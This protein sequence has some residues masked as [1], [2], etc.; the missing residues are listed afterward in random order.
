MTLNARTCDPIRIITLRFQHNYVVQDNETITITS[1]KISNDIKFNHDKT[2]ILQ[3]CNM[4]LRLTFQTNEATKWFSCVFEFYLERRLR[5]QLMARE[6]V[7]SRRA[8]DCSFGS[9]SQRV[10]SQTRDQKP[11]LHTKREVQ[12]R[13]TIVRREIMPTSLWRGL[14][15]AGRAAQGARGSW[16]SH[17]HGDAR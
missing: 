17:D 16:N 11:R 9:S 5:Y 1:F 7:K 6:V 14:S 12:Q 13:I 15:S 8:W 3:S 2:T 4:Q 10:A